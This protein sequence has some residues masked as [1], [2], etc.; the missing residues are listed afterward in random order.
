MSY[1]LMVFSPETAPRTRPEFMTWY[2]SQ[3][4][5]Q[6]EHNYDDPANCSV[7]LLNW[8][9]DMI[10]VFPALNGPFATDNPDNYFAT[11]Y[12][13]GKEVIYAAFSWPVAEKAYEVMKDMAE[14]HKVGFF[15]AS[16]EEGDILFPNESGKSEPIDGPGNP[17]S[18]QQ[19]RS[20]A[21]PGQE[22]YSIADIVFSKL[23][24]QTENVNTPPTKQ[25]WWSK[26]FGFK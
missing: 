2:S 10:K 16:A 4:E 21:K 9:Q 1:D 14:K 20:W 3:S 19:I 23:N 12:C 17:S 15:D 18:I 6:E 25:K 13:I 24:L 26:F 22:N 5:W 8:F 7:E 11:D